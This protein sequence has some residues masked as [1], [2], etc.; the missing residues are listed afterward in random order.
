MHLRTNLC[1]I[2]SSIRDLFFFFNDTATTEIY[3]LSLHDALP[4]YQRPQPVNHK[5]LALVV[6]QR[7]EELPPRIEG[8]DV[9]IAEIA[10]E[11]RAAEPAKGEGGLRDAPRRIQRPLAREAP[12]QL[13]VGVEHVDKA[14]ARPR[15]VVA[16]VLTLLRVGDEEIAVDGL[17]TERR[18][19]R[20]QL[21]IGEVALNLH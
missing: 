17:D 9:P 12:Q 7:P 11:D 20:R 19:P 21:R 4:I 2:S 18:E 16:F 8:V 10:N 13:P 6:P 3:T 5:R 15:H 1:S 14:M